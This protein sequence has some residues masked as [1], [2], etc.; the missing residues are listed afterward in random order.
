MA[1]LTK[2]PP[3][4]DLTLIEHLNEDPP[5][6]AMWWECEDCGDYAWLWPGETP[7]ECSCDD[8]GGVI[9]YDLDVTR[10]GYQTDDRILDAI[11]AI[12]GGN[13]LANHSADP[14]RQLWLHGGREAEIRAWLDKHRPNWRDEAPLWWGTELFHKDRP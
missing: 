9:A 5:R 12:T 1:K 14:A 10:E 11:E 8:E 4:L 7:P 6:R 13:L 3:P 2:R